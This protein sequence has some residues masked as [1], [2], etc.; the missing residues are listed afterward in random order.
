[1]ATLGSEPPPGVLIDAAI[2][3]SGEYAA[4]VAAGVGVFRPAAALA[5]FATYQRA[6]ATGRQNFSHEFQMDSAR[7]T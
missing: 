6:P 1:M 4:S 2:P 3:T 5:V 7:L